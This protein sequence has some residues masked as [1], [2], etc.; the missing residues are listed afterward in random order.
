MTRL[1]REWGLPAAIVTGWFVALVWGL[2]VAMTPKPTPRLQKTMEI[3]VVGARRA[4][5]PS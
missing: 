3:P 2:T 5:H 1:L 4:A